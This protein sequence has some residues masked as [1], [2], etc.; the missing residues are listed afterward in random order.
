M[1]WLLY[2]C[3]WNHHRHCCSACLPQ[4][5]VGKHGTTL[6]VFPEEQEDR[7]GEEGEASGDGGG[8]EEEEGAAGGRGRGRG[9]GRS[10]SDTDTSSSGSESSGES[11]P[12]DKMVHDMPRWVSEARGTGR[13]IRAWLSCLVAV[14]AQGSPHPGTRWCMTCQGGCDTRG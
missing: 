14:T 13:G 9:E 6:P 4:K 1:R 5:L 8:E 11:P 7:L 12:R 10:G 2:G 3:G